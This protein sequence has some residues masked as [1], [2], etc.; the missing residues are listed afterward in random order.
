MFKGSPLKQLS[1]LKY[2]AGIFSA[3][4]MRANFERFV[5]LLESNREGGAQGAEAYKARRLRVNFRMRF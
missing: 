3:V 4:S 2:V 1:T 5:G